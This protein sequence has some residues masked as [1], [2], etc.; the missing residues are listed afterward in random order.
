MLLGFKKRFKS[1]VK[2]GTKRHTIRDKRKIPGKVGQLCHCY[3]G[4]RQK[5]AELLGRWP[6]TRIEDI[7]IEALFSTGS[8]SQKTRLLAMHV[9]IW[10][11]GEPL[12]Q[13]ETTQLCWQDGFRSTTIENAWREFA[14]F[15]IREHRKNLGE[16]LTLRFHGDLVHWDYDHPQTVVVKPKRKAA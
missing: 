3:T 10:I 9:R 11:N 4:L 16:D 15:W 5:G 13:T 1:M 12:S 8:K 2:D 7:R 6:C 14:D